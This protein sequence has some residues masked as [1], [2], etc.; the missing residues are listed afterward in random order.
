[1]GTSQATDGKNFTYIEIIRQMPPEA[2]TIAYQGL[3]ALA[4]VE[5]LT[6][7]EKYAEAL[8]LLQHIV[9]NMF[10]QSI[11]DKCKENPFDLAVRAREEEEGS[12]VAC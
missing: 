12:D 9:G 3:T 2:Q 10:I 1:M 11:A 7:E 6:S 5:D 8:N 4:R